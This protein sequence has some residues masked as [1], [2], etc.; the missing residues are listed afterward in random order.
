MFIGQAAQI[1][2]EY[3]SCKTYGVV[4]EALKTAAD[5]EEKARTHFDG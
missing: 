2:A 3:G 4:L 1:E 5:N